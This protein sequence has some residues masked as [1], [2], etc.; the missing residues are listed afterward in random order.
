MKSLSFPWYLVLSEEVQQDTVHATAGIG[1]YTQAV[2]GNF[3]AGIL[4]GGIGGYIT[5]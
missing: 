1:G 4:E 3:N 2:E 5:D